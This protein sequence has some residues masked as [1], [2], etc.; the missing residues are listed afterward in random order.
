MV[1]VDASKSKAMDLGKVIKSEVMKEACSHE[2]EVMEERRSMILK[3]CLAQVMLQSKR[4]HSR[5][6]E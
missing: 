3:P 4:P 6:S 1:G 2:P 5:N